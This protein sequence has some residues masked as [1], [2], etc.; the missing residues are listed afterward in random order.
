MPFG[1]NGKSGWCLWCDFDRDTIFDLKRWV[2]IEVTEKIRV[3]AWDFS[4]T[5][6]RLGAGRGNI[7][8]IMTH[9]EMTKDQMMAD[10]LAWMA[11]QV[12][13]SFSSLATSS[14][15]TLSLR[16]PHCSSRQ[17]RSKF[18]LASAASCSIS[19]ARFSSDM[20]KVDWAL[21]DC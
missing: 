3:I 15:A 11:S 6:L 17:D 16:S 9:V 19:S 7:P 21:S 1:W 12:D 5:K 10:L 13:K 20:V 8:S 4:A 2:G 18:P 14:A